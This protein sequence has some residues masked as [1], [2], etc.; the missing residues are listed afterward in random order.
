MP[1]SYDFRYRRLGLANRMM[2]LLEEIS[3]KTYNGYFVDLF[4]RRSNDVAVQ[5]YEKLGYV[6]YRTVLDYYS[7]E[8]S[9]DAFGG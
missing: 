1:G 9:E 5:L 6:I 2:Y 8:N 3:E 4:V 7:G